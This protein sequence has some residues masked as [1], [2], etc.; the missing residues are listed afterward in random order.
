MTSMEVRTRTRGGE[1]RCRRC[2]WDRNGGQLGVPY[3][4]AHTCLSHE[5]PGQA[6]ARQRARRLAQLDRQDRSRSADPGAWRSRTINAEFK[7][8]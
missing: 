2:A 4:P 1:D 5:T 6:A 8:Y 3:P 7:V